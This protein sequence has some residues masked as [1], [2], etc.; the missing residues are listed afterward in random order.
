MLK[1][2]FSKKGGAGGGFTLVELLVVMAIIAVL[3]TLIIAAITIARRA[4]RDTQRRDNMSAVKGALEDYYARRKMYPG[5]TTWTTV[6]SLA[7]SDADF[8]RSVPDTIKDPQSDT[9]L[10]SLTDSSITQR[11]CY[12]RTD[13]AGNA[14]TSKYQLW[15]RT[16]SYS[17]G[18]PGACSANG[19]PFSME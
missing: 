9:A 6:S 2:L 3:I 12:R 11:Y 16:E 5:G 7:L 18:N 19:E 8:S 1:K 15:L 13:S 14:N 10:K 17:S 4:S